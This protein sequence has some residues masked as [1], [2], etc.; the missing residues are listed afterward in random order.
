MTTK[1]K[2]K[3]VKAWA[4]IDKDS[5]QIQILGSTGMAITEYEEQIK[6]GWQREFPT[7]PLIYVP[8]EIHLLT[9]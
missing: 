4:V 8:C 9:Q 2:T 7:T 6:L 3:I 1:P 5:G